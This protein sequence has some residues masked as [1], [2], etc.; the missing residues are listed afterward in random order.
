MKIKILLMAA[1]LGLSSCTILNNLDEIST[2]GDYSREKDA[3][4]KWVKLTTR[5]YEA[6][7]A[8][9]DRG[10]MGRYTDQ[11]S[12]VKAFGQPILKK[13]LSDGSQRWLYRKAVYKY[14]KDKVYIYFD[15]GG[16]VIKWERLPCQKLF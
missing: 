6:L 7:T 5:H 15:H 2:L 14:A 1:C 10:E 13:D 9:I 16:N 11:A 8:A 3:Q 12:V 4:H